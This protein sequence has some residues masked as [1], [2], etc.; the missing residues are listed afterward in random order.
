MEDR[1]CIEFLQSALPRLRLRWPGFR[2]V[3]NQVCKRIN[4]RISELGSPDLPSYKRLLDDNP[5]EWEILDSLCRITISR[6]YRDRGVFDILHSRILPALA[7]KASQNGTDQIRCWS[8]GCCSGE[9]AYT[10][11]ILWKMCLVPGMKQQLQLRIIATD[12]DPAV[13]ERAQKGVYP[14]SSLVDLPEGLIQQAFICS[15]GAC[16][17]TRVCREDIEFAL[18]DIR[19]RMPE[20]P[21]HLILCRNVVFTYFE[22]DLQLEI[23]DRIME[24]LAPGGIFIIG[25]HESLPKGVSTL[26]P[27]NKIPGIYIMPP[28]MPMVQS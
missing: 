22:E 26:I 1:E 23:H 25:I 13:L 7:K 6:F 9:E 14:E 11:Q 10:L 17:I 2:R 24:R 28:I 3:R 19:E 12:I 8:A 21:F 4:R 5:E 16:S 27:Y 20:G 15:G 18:Q